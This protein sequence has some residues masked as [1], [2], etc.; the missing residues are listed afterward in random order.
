M[1]ILEACSIDVHIVKGLKKE[2]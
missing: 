1:N 2:C